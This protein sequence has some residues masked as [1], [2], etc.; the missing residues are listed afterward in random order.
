MASCV[1]VSNG[2]MTV[3]T[4][5]KSFNS[6]LVQVEIGMDK[7]QAA[8]AIAAACEVEFTKVTATG[9]AVLA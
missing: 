9:E 1:S 6:Q 3:N 4:A 5:G 2:S 7:N 8:K